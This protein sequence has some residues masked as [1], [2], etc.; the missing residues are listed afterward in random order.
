LGFAIIQIP[1]LT[2]C[3]G[4]AWNSKIFQP[5]IRFE[6]KLVGTYFPDAFIGPIGSLMQALQ[7]DGVPE[8]DGADNLRTLRIIEAA[9]I[10]AAQNRS[11][12]LEEVS[13][14]L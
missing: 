1:S 7:E 10:S 12:R 6:A 9:Y 3:F 13:L 14:G 11:V 5:E 4:I 2:P 8:T